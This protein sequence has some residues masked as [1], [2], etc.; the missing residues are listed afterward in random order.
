MNNDIRT[1]C[2]DEALVNT[3][4]MQIIQCAVKVFVKKGYDRTNMR[5]LAKACNMSIGSLYHYVSSKND[6]LYLI[7]N[8]GLSMLAESVEDFSSRSRDVS[9]TEGLRE[10]IRAYYHGVDDGQD[11]T[12]FT[13]QE[14]KNLNPDAR[15]SILDS[16][17]RDVAAC[18][19]LLRGGVEAGEFKIDNPTLVAHDIIVSGHA[20]AFRRWFLR[21][22]CTL[23]E[24]IREK[25][26]SI[27]KAILV[28]TRA[29][30][31]SQQDTEARASAGVH[32]SL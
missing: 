12:L 27:L 29:A 11:F 21:K 10:F 20:W 14:T 13:Y 23:E 17:A 4:R 1:Y 18:E 6:I 7:V 16:A 31:A 2:S 8:H 9:P 5:E 3:R 32:D 22:R 19:A 25:T 28:D 26:E 24:Y 15:R 30:I